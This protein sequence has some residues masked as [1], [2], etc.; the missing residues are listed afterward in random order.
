MNWQAFGMAWGAVAIAF[1]LIGIMGLWG[2]VALVRFDWPDW[3][4][5]A[6]PIG[7]FV[8]GIP[9]VIGLTT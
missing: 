4:Y 1:G 3:V 9:F 7:L 2:W 6:V 5:W 8:V